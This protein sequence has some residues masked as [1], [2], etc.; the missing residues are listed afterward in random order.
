MNFFCDHRD[1]VASSVAWLRYGHRTL[2]LGSA[3]LIAACGGNSSVVANPGS[4]NDGQLADVL[5]TA[6]AG[7]GVP[8]MA[9][10]LI[11]DGM[12]IEMAAV[13]TRVINEPE[14][15]TVDDQWHL[16]SISK[17]ITSTLAAVLN[18]QG[19][20][21]W[22]TTVSDV[23]LGVIP[24][25]RNEYR[26]VRVEQLMAHTGGLP[27]DVTRS[28]A[29]IAG[30]LNDTSMIPMTDNRLM[31]SAD[32]L[33]MAPEAGVGAHLYSNAN[34]IV[35]G[36]IIEQVTGEQ[37]EDL[38]QRELFA[39][40]GMINSGFGAPGV[41]GMR[42]QPWGHANVGG[43]W[44]AFDPGSFDADNTLA[45]GPAGTVHSTLRDFSA[46]IAARLGG[47]RGIDGLLAAASFARLHTPQ[48]GTSYGGG[49]V[50]D[51]DGW[52]GTPIIWHKGSN[53]RWFAEV[54]IARD[55]NAAVFVATNSK[56]RA[57]VEDVI[58]V[59]IRRFER[60]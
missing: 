4:A 46:Y 58:N 42:T 50:V 26:N 31:W 30:D 57:A 19:L 45:I 48:P 10:M 28:P 35:L 27:V 41:A 60:M 47:A 2:F 20:L 3:F 21:D 38:M 18:E 39:P 25:M 55:K 12:I 6:R 56:S 33:R 59:M 7:H 53:G 16:G 54:V 17:S 24:D 40:L 8:A 29:F 23:L 1:H 9:A 44:Q 22:D 43:T 14:L 36:A 13:G 51:A 49:W 15:V 34:Y 11:E 52:A 37:W 32:L 5:E